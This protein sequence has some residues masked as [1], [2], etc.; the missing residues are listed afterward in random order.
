VLS[1]G[2][3]LNAWFCATCL[4]GFL[5][6]CNCYELRCEGKVIGG[7]EADLWKIRAAALPYPRATVAAGTVHAEKVE[8][9]AARVD[10]S[11]GTPAAGLRPRPAREKGFPSNLLL[12]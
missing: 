4:S 11:Q 3:W 2:V 5:C 9:G 6:E 7:L 1:L 8:R 12:D 10:G